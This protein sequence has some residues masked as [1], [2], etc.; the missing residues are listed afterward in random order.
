MA[1]CLKCNTENRPTAKL[2]ANCGAPL[3]SAGVGR[4]ST[5]V[6]YVGSNIPPT[7]AE[8]AG[9]RVI[10]PTEYEERPVRPPAAE[11][12]QR[13]PTPVQA[14]PATVLHEEAS[15]PIAGWLVVLRSPSVPALPVYKD[16]PIFVGANTLGRNP[17]FGVHALPD[18]KVSQ[19]HCVIVGGKEQVE[20]TDL[21]A[22]NHTIVNNEIIHTRVLKRGDM[23]KLGRTTFVFVPM[24]G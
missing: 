9:G 4:A 11:A 7:V 23:V 17:A 20:I 1:R 15:K 3:M 16:I 14:A 8:G 21:G 18:D 19:Q 24:G 13:V 12:Q 22:A 10:P 2:C 6:P 5:P